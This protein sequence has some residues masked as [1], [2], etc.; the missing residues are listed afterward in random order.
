[1][2][3]EQK[4]WFKR[5]LEV[6]SIKNKEV[7]NDKP[8]YLYK[9]IQPTGLMYGQ[10][11]LPKEFK[12]AEF[13][14][15]DTAGKMK[16][17]LLNGFI[18][19]AI[20]PSDDLIPDDPDQFLHYLSNSLVEYYTKVVPNRK[21]RDRNFWG[22]KLS[23]EEMIESMLNERLDIESP[24][25]NNFWFNFF[26]HSLLFLDVFFFG[27]WIVRK[28]SGTNLESIQ[29]ERDNM[30]VLLLQIMAAAAHADETLQ[31]EEQ[32]LFNHFLA[33]AHLPEELEKKAKQFIIEGTKIKDIHTEHIENWILKK[34]LLELAVLTIWADKVVTEEE[35]AFISVLAKQLGFSD[36]EL[37]SSMAA[38]E[39][40]VI[41]NWSDVPFIQEKNTFST[42]SDGFIH[43]ISVVAKKNQGRIAKEIK[44]SEELMQLLIKSTHE[45][46]TEDEKIKVRA[47]LIDILK[48]LPTFVLIALPGSFLTLPLLLK[49]LPKSVLP[50]AFQ[51]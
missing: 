18:K 29:S 6:Y 7:K 51:E 36:D 17:V 31:E 14:E 40:F 22:K 37:Q 20:F 8:S 42:I 13:R 48:V 35:Q 32:E 3:L 28:E 39:S 9:E 16:I 46:L 33:S 27:E 43:R 26:N 4:G 30:H 34:Y 25:P 11:S 19:T 1:M 44:E 49:V 21:I 41:T 5:L 47:Q 38:I 2:D 50:S 45:S 15:L 12:T 10:P 23:N 24:D